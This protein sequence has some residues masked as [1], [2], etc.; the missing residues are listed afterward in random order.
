[1]VFVKSMISMVYINYFPTTNVLLCPVINK[2]YSA[3]ENQ[4]FTF[5][6]SV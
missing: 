3:N 2:Q 1:M 5:I 4:D 6:L